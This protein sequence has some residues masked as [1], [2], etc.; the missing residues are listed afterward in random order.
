[1]SF[2][3]IQ[4]VTEIPQPAYIN[5]K[6]ITLEAFEVRDVPP[7]VAT[8]FLAQRPKQ[9]QVYRPVVVPIR[10]GEPVRWLANMTGNPFQP[11]TLDKYKMD[12]KSGMEE[13]F[14]VPNPLHTAQLVSREMH[15]E[16]AVVQAQQG[17]FKESVAHLP[18][19]VKIPPYTRYPFPMSIAEWMERRDSQMDENS[20]GKI[21]ACR[22]PTAF[23]PNDSWPHAEIIIFAQMVDPQTRWASMYKIGKGEDEAAAAKNE[24]LH[25]LFFRIVDE[26]FALPPEGAF[27]AQ[28][29]KVK[30][31]MKQ[32]KLQAS[33][34]QQATA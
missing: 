9:V 1:M 6:R 26:R 27:Q 20:V 3:S 16:D 10:H 5:D 12:K 13:K 30:E 15:V 28:L 4:N 25:A 29:A 7:E 19:T 24:L 32:A 23:E 18:I 22:A 34:G 2:V 11:K 8:A 21:Q 33:S 17:N 14:T 31:E